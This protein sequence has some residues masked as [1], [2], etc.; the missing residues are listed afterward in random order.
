MYLSKCL[1]TRI[2][3]FKR[4]CRCRRRPYTRNDRYDGRYMLT[5]K[6]DFL[7]GTLLKKETVL[8]V[9]EEHGEGTV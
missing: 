4:R 2:R 3:I 6:G 8:R 9:E 5:G 1:F 7:R